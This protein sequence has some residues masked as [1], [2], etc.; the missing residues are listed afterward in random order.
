MY[1]RGQ[2]KKNL[3]NLVLIN[4]KCPGVACVGQL[5]GGGGTQGRL[6]I[7]KGGMD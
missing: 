7:G 2:E 6:R 3:N 5:V 1:S 4:V